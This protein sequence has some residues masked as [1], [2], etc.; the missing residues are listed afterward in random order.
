[1]PEQ[2]EKFSSCG[3]CGRTILKGEE[4]HEYVSPPG[5]RHG[6]CV[7]CRSEAEAS[8]WIP[9]EH[10]A[11]V[12]HEPASRGRR[13][14]ALRKR[15]GQ[16]ASRA[17]G[18]AR[19]AR[20]VAVREP[21]ARQPSEAGRGPSDQRP[22]QR[23]APPPATAT[24]PGAEN[25]PA[26][27]PKRP[28]RPQAKSSPKGQATKH[29]P[30][31]Q[32]ARRTPQRRAPGP[33]RGPEAIMRKAVQRFNASDESRKVAGLIRSLGEPQ[34]AVRPDASRQLAL[35]TIAWELSWYQ[36]EVSGGDDGETVREVAK[37][38][39]VAEL[40][41]DSRAWNAAVAEDGSLRLRSGSSRQKVSAT[42]A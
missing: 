6:V 19:S 7:L 16:A 41:Q 22:G 34:A 42:E 18:A 25:G 28:P 5:Q 32:A 21:D 24:L 14:Q 3:V 12:A 20:N 17:R 9:A 35:V 10:Y 11:T 13:G 4:V 30:K 39:E 8:G 23:A 29:S 2:P 33:R 31:G 40:A 27:R 1:V 38:K 36:W 15:L 26:E 37:G